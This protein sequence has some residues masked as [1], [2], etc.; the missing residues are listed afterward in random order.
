MSIQELTS[1]AAVMD[2]LGGV[3][4]VMQ[5]TGAS[6]K[7]AFN[8]KSF[9][10]FPSKTYVAMTDALSRA[11]KCAPASLWGMTETTQ[12]REETATQERMPS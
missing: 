12:G 9:P 3:P 10:T 1:T 5:I 6:Y 11:G 2:A 7:A 4:G 8:W